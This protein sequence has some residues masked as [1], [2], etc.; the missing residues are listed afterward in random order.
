MGVGEPGEFSS[1][2][3]TIDGRVF[4][5]ESQSPEGLQA[6]RDDHPSPTQST[7]GLCFSRARAPASAVSS[8]SPPLP[9]ILSAFSRLELLRLTGGNRPNMFYF[10]DLEIIL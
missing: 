9:F 8:A 5:V 4:S 10:Q 3:P 6:K 2:D 1:K 7:A